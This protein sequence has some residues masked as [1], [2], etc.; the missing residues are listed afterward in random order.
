M[1][2][3]PLEPLENE[4]FLV[5]SNGMA[6][7][8]KMAMADAGGDPPDAKASGI[9]AALSFSL[10]SRF[11]W[12]VYRAVLGPIDVPESSPFDKPE[13]LWRLMKLLPLCLDQPLYEPIRRFLSDDQ[14][15]RKRYQLAERLADLF[16]QYQVYRSDWLEAWARGSNSL[17]THQGHERPLPEPTLWQPSL[18][19][20]LLLDVA[21]YPLTEPLNPPKDVL[22]RA[23]VHARFIDKARGWGSLERPPRLPRRLMIFGLSSLPRQSLEVL[24]VLSKWTQIFVSIQNPSEHY[25]SDIVADRELLNP[26]RYQRQSRKANRPEI[27]SEE[28]LH[29][30]AHPLLA[31]W[32]RQGRD[33]IALLDELDDPALRGQYQPLL[34]GLNR[35]IDCFESPGTATLLQQLQDDIRDLRPLSESKPL[36]PACDPRQDHSIRFHVAHG[37]LREVE[38]L[39]DQLLALLNEVSSLRPRDIMVMVP[40]IEAF[41]PH[42]Q[43]VFGLHDPGSERAIPFTL[44]DQ[45]RRTSD[46]LIKALEKL[47]NLPNA[48]LGVSE[49]L[50][51]LDVVALRQRF[52]IKPSDI[53]LYHRWIHNA[54][55]RWG[56]HGA[57]R[58][59]LGLLSEDAVGQNT[60]LF[61]CRRLLLG[62]ATGDS[63]DE[64]Q[65]IIP[66]D[67][68]GG[69]EASSLG[70]LIEFLDQLEKAWSALSE[71]RSPDEWALTLNAL[72]EDFFDPTGTDDGLTVLEMERQLEDWRVTCERSGY[73]EPLP[74]S[75]LKDHWLAAL[76]GQGLSQ[77]YLAGA[78][79]FATL[80][81]MRAIPFEVVCLLG[82]NDGDYPRPRNTLDFDL[83]AHDV[84]PGDRSRREDDRYLFLEALLAA[85][86]HLHISWVGHS[87]N[88]HTERPPSVLVGQLRDHLAAG[89]SLA[90]D[91]VPGF[92][93]L[94][95]ALTTVHPLQP[96][97][98]RYFKR[99][100]PPSGLFSF[101]HEWISSADERDS[102]EPPR[103]N[104]IEQR[105][106]PPVLDE[107]LTLRAITAFLQCPA[108][109]FFQEALAIFFHGDE[110]PSEDVEPFTLSPLDRWSLG[111]ALIQHQ[112]GFIKN[113]ESQ[114]IDSPSNGLM[115]S[116]NDRATVFMRR[117]QA[118][119]ALVS[120]SFGDL[121]LEELKTSHQ[122]LL[123]SWEAILVEWPHEKNNDALSIHHEIHLD[124]Q[125][126]RLVDSVEGLRFNDQGD[127]LHLV[128]EASDLKK[129]G[130]YRKDVIAR[131]WVTHLALNLEG[132][133]IKT[134]ILS[135]MDSVVLEPLPSDEAAHH[136]DH[137]L[138]AWFEGM[139][140]PLPMALKTGF[141]W[142]EEH[143]HE[144]ARKAYE[145]DPS[146]PG[147]GIRNPYLRRAFPSFK[148]LFETGV[149][150][151]WA[152]Q[153]LEPLHQMILHQEDRGRQRG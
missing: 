80:M 146:R 63:V 83:M 136:L 26:R 130:R 32:G 7:W 38:I 141:A 45:N 25:W 16:D 99:L 122:A 53:P 42:I 79:T 90:N 23:S 127:L 10:P 62:Y 97:S 113:I 33:F 126:I 147:E 34:Q 103:G 60:W 49:V 58:T 76:G 116:L 112:R 86:R 88:D 51:F 92:K 2:R 101:A 15:L 121:A 110:E 85:R 21:E 27:L 139:Q 29:L 41:A 30:H 3:Y 93:Q 140:R 74:L 22:S 1:D 59:A 11:L 47:L 82:M 78:V 37:P 73:Q 94:M 20:S 44:A 134:Q 36:W 70:P 12:Q 64:W 135:K 72:I 104:P 71:I 91:V 138:E 43:A 102:Q 81:P 107:P 152:H 124:G 66:S 149:F 153:L 128:L 13:L 109:T 95:E 105:L 31:A 67:D 115:A 52:R 18:W 17:I 142:I 14:D 133:K 55:I 87:I 148:A 8:L 6:Q 68:I 125:V 61:G 118:K 24:E 144:K 123:P 89:W 40:D 111:E 77:G 54:H 108:K 48:R 117:Y 28:L 96:F 132:R 75:I 119:G 56:L 114:G 69:L 57:H 106:P 143:D 84:R 145:G 50:D 35:R 9:A 65:G 100:D 19:R 98:P 150:E 151:S 131:H 46:P 5:Q 4:V 129:D 120:D 137:L 39:H